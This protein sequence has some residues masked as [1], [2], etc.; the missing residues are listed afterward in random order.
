M[1]QGMKIVV[2]GASGHLGGNLIPQLIDAGYSVH[3]I[4]RVAVTGDMAPGGDLGIEFT[5]ADLTDRAK[6]D[7]ALAGADLVVHCASIHPWKPYPDEEY[8]DANEK[9]TWALYRGCVDAGL[10]RVVLTS[11]VAAVGY[12][13]GTADSWP[14]GEDYAGLPL[15]LYSL[16]K[17]TQE[18]IARQFQAV[19]GVN[20]V[21]LRPPA[22]M[23]LDEVATGHMLLGVYAHV[24]D[25]VA[26]HVAAVKTMLGERETPRPLEPFEAFFTTNQHPYVADDVALMDGE[27]VTVEL[28]AKYWPE[29]AAWLRDTEFTGTWSPAVYDNAKAREMLGWQARMDFGTWFARN[30]AGKGIS[31]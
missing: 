14:L 28:A 16:T 17:Q 26:A 15:D 11:S 24:D 7:A 20:T 21:A 4:D 19:H 2:T 6:L 25:I 9:G 29:A 3:G 23:P 31:A 1:A 8:F 12:G 30:T 13:M 10:D 18:T 22:F 27:S 5:A